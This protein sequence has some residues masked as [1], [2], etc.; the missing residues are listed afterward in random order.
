MAIGLVDFVKTASNISLIDNMLM[1][2]D[3]SGARLSFYNDVQGARSG[4]QRV[5]ADGKNYQFQ[6]TAPDYFCQRKRLFFSS[7]NGPKAVHRE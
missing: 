6:V 7:T 3:S 1:M 4:D 2:I 5:S